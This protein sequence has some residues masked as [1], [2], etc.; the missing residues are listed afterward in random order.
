MRKDIRLQM[1][2]LSIKKLYTIS[3]KVQQYKSM[4]KISQPWI[5]MNFHSLYQNIATIVLQIKKRRPR[6]TQAEMEQERAGGMTIG[7]MLSTEGT[8]EP[9]GILK[10]KRKCCKQIEA[11]TPEETK[12]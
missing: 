11:G 2:K 3:R 5:Y 4:I 9:D 7:R 6:R 12:C 8:E 1:Y 10:G